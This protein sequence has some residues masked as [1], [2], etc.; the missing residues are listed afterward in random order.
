VQE[1]RSADAVAELKA[2]LKEFPEHQFAP[3]AR[4][5]L[6]KLESTSTQTD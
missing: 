4:E 1:K 6:K 2:F 3:K 5:V